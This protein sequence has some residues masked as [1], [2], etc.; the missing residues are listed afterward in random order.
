MLTKSEGERAAIHDALDTLLEVLD[1]GVM[2]SSGL[3]RNYGNHTR[4]TSDELAGLRR[5]IGNKARGDLL[6]LRSKLRVTSDN[7][8]AHEEE[9]IRRRVEVDE[10][11]V[12]LRKE[13]KKM[14][15]SL[16]PHPWRA[17]NTPE[18]TS[19]RVCVVKTRMSETGYLNFDLYGNGA[20]DL[21]LKIMEPFVTDRKPSESF[22]KGN[23]GEARFRVF[24]YKF[25]R[26]E[27]QKEET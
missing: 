14:G 8:N 26:L 16:K 27:I 25:D 10:I 4:I 22:M 1:H 21:G 12:Y 7:E 2:A 5:A 15:L 20:W 24:G 3:S 11:A 19:A 13:L 23:P 6:I 9:R 17:M 18:V